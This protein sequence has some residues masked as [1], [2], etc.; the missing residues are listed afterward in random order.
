[1][2]TEREIARMREENPFSVPDRDLDYPVETLLDK[3]SFDALNRLVEEEG[4]VYRSVL[5]RHLV[6]TYLTQRSALPM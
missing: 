2:A 4:W 5:L 1:M 3:P 6:E